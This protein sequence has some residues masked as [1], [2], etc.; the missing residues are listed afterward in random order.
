MVGSPRSG[1][2]I[3]GKVFG[4][5]GSMLFLSE[6]RPA[7]YRAVPEFDESLFHWEGDALWGRIY[8]DEND[9]TPQV[10]AMLEEDFGRM[11]ALAGRR[12][13]MEKMPINLFRVRWLNA[14][15]P[16]AKFVQI[17]RDPFGTTSS[18]T[19]CWPSIDEQELP[20]VAIRRRMFARLFPEL[21]DLLDTVRSSY[22]WYLF[23]WRMFTEEGERLQAMFPERYTIVRLEDAQ[24]NPSGVFEKLCAFT[25][26][27]VTRR[28]RRAYR[29]W[30]DPRLRMAKPQLDPARCR[31]LLGQSAERWGYTF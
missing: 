20:G 30:L 23:E 12:R 27:P 26:L 28:L 9:V 5:Q 2:T 16:D 25:G 17:M 6:A 8:M 1:T 13:L 15:W 19:Q 11:L 29:L 22:E 21:K 3:L 14:M 31:E 10:K 4:H 7:W 24:T 18:K